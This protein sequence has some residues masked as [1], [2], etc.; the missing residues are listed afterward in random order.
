MGI[1]K[2][3][4]IDNQK[5]IPL[6]RIIFGTTRVFLCFFWYWLYNII[7]NRK[8]L[9]TFICAKLEL[10]SKKKEK[11]TRTFLFYDLSQVNSALWQM[12]VQIA[13]IS[14]IHYKWRTVLPLIMS[15]TMSIIN[16]IDNKICQCYFFSI[17]IER[18]FKKSSP[19]SSLLKIP[20]K[21]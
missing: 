6:F 16:L 20:K 4:N 3:I 10:G 14:I 1:K 18:P 15:S 7:S 8:N 17:P 9:S 12:L 2:N 19:F 21:K 13:F 11:I 5:L